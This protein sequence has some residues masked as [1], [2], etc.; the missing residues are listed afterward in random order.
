[1]VVGNEPG[2]LSVRL[3]RHIT[4]LCPQ[5]RRAHRKVVFGAMAGAVGAFAPWLATA[6]VTF[7]QGA[8][9]GPLER[10]QWAQEGLTASS[11]GGGRLVFHSSQTTCTTGLILPEKNTYFNLFVRHGSVAPVGLPTRKASR[12]RAAAVAIRASSTETDRPSQSIRAQC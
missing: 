4:H 3:L 8:A 2:N 6:F 10:R 5:A 11:Q 7:D 12:H 1:M 9:P